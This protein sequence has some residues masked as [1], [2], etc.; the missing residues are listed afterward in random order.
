MEIEGFRSLEALTAPAVE[1][2]DNEELGKTQFLE[3]MI[4]Q[5][6]NQDPLDPAKNEDFI[7]QLAQFSTVEG[8]ENLNTSFDNMA[9]SMQASLTLQSAS[10]VGRDVLVTADQGLLT[11]SGMNGLVNLP[12]GASDLL[13]DISTAGGELVAQLELGSREAGQARFGWNGLDAE[14]QPL[15]TGLYQVRAY[16]ALAGQSQAFET[17]LPNR[18]TSVAIGG[19]EV[20]ADLLGGTTIPTTDI[21]SIQ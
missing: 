9:T 18:V 16:S 19:G 21:I 7:A 10:L 20:T 8:I 5:L 6:E 1:R 13:V 3:L 17:A 2:E 12:S 14:G 15:P 11:E 4:A